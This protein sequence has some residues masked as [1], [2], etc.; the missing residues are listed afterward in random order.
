MLLIIVGK[1]DVHSLKNHAQ[2]GLQNQ[3]IG[4]IGLITLN[5]ILRIR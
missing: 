5:T 1:V 3:R 2:T 4:I